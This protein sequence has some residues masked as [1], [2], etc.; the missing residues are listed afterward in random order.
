MITL[1]GTTAGSIVP[2]LALFD[3]IMG[4]LADEYVLAA[5]CATGMRGQIDG[6]GTIP[7]SQAELSRA[8]NG[9]RRSAVEAVQ[10]G[11]T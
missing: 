11:L 7:S 5:A 4:N 3:S 9:K 10:P 2:P 6:A 8:S 1:P